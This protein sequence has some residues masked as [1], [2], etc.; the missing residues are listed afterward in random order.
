MYDYLFAPCPTLPNQR[1]IKSPG[2]CFQHGPFRLQ[3]TASLEGHFVLPKESRDEPRKKPRWKL[4]N[5]I[6]AERIRIK[7]QESASRSNADD[8]EE[9]RRSELAGEKLSAS[10]LGSI[11]GDVHNNTDEAENSMIYG[12]KPTAS[13][14]EPSAIATGSAQRS[15]NVGSKPTRDSVQQ[16]KPRSKSGSH[17]PSSRKSSE[18]EE[19]MKMQSFFNEFVSSDTVQRAIQVGDIVNHERYGIGRF[20]G[21]E[22]TYSRSTDPSLGIQEF[23]V[24]EYRDGDV[25]VPPSHFDLITS[26]NKDEAKNV[27]QFDVLSGASSYTKTQV[28]LRS[29]RASFLARQ[30]TRQKIRQQLVN[31]HG[32]YAQR[33]TIERKPFTVNTRAEDSFNTSRSFELTD[34]QRKAIS[35]VMFDMSERLRPMDRLLCGDVGFGKTEVAMCAALRALLAGRQVAVL[36]PTTILAQQHFETFRERFEDA[37]LDFNIACFTRFVPRKIIMAQRQAIFE[38]KLDIAIGTHTLLNDNIQFRDL[39]LLIVDEEHRFGVNQ[40]ERI[41]SRYRWTDTLFLT[42]TPIPRTLHMSLSGLRDVSVLR[43]PPPGRKP[44]ITRI[45]QT[46]SG[47]VR[48]AIRHEID[49]G[50]QVFFVVPRVEGIESTATWIRELFTDDRVKVMVAHGSMKDL[51]QRVWAFSKK[52]YNVLLCTTIIENGIHIPEANTIIIQDAARFGLAQL[53]QLRGRVGRGEVQ[54]FALLLYTSRTT[55]TMSSF[56]RLQALEANSQLGA[57]FAIAQKDM[58]M[59]GVGTVLGVEQHGNNAVGAEEYAKMLAEELEHARTGKPVPITLPVT[60]KVEI[61]LPVS[62]LIPDS[63]VGDFEN[64]MTLYKFMSDC[65]DIHQLVKVTSMMEKIYG[66]MPPETRRHVSLLEVK[67]YAKSLGIRKVTV[68]RNHV[69]L[70]WPIGAVAFSRLVA[71]LPDKQSRQRCELIEPEERTIIR[72][73]GTC[74]G[75]MQLAKLRT[76]FENFDKAAEGLNRDDGEKT[77]EMLSTALLRTEQKDN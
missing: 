36:S 1:P 25:F 14:V 11:L 3:R 54:A 30:R 5:S 48:T 31:L 61:F 29:R 26:L 62:S 72:G 22:R 33:T 16:R 56:Q 69:V 53:H 45:A 28:S 59:R 71:F 8:E 2:R 19:I 12:M 66:V 57:G 32:L 27:K 50:G 64:K 46:G 67:L 41:R 55:G 40:K 39:G 58:E 77:T 38:G 75:V 68:E 35:Q 43:I 65:T 37:S 20:V 63:Y 13:I 42:A 52:E 47:I 17:T 23:A 73:L 74:S 6:S 24:L 7:N 4:P 18:N 44:V 34:D 49:R 51:E 70:D 21:L 10:D 76:L 60:N 9:I 15:Q